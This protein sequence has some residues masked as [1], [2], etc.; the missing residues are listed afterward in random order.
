MLTLGLNKFI[1]CLKEVF[2]CDGCYLT[3]NRNIKTCVH[4]YCIYMLVYVSVSKAINVKKKRAN[5]QCTHL[6]WHAPNIHYILEHCVSV[7]YEQ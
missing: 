5:L 7:L 1:D 6:Y 4:I 2:S 3:L